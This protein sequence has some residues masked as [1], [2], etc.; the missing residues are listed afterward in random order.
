MKFSW[1]E[2]KRLQ[3]LQKHRLDFRDVP[4]AFAEET[5][6]IPDQ[7]FDYAEV[8]FVTFSILEGVVVAIVHTETDEEIRV[9]SFRR[10][11]PREERYYYAEIRD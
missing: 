5:V 6:T 2:K 3:N 7:R 8:R 1:D 10:A 4:A 11:T 9:I